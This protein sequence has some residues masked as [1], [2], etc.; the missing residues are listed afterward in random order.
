MLLNQEKSVLAFLMPRYTEKGEMKN[1]GNG[2]LIFGREIP[3]YGVFFFLGILLAAGAAL[4]LAHKKRA[5]P[6]YEVV[7]S[8]V[9]TMIGAILGAKLLFLAVSLPELIRESIPI[10]AAIKG[11]FVF[12]GGF[13]GGFLGLWIYT[14]QFKM[15]LLPFVCLYATVVPLGHAFG[16]VGCYFAGCCYGIPYDGW[17]AVVYHETLGRT[18][19][20][21][22][23]FPV[24]LLESLLLLCLFAVLLVLYL[25]DRG[26]LCPW[27]YLASYGVIRFLLEFLRYD[28]ERGRL[29]WLST[30]QW[31]SVGLLLWTWAWQGGLLARLR[32]KSKKKEGSS[33][34]E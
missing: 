21:V 28:A 14:K 33:H 13:L 26:A 29:L 12:Y 24:Q 19:L 6:L 10:I 17:G 9:Y 22:P 8:A 30:S 2:F 4:L 20:E 31:V 5:M 23:L 15:K 3:L 27:V 11:G 7:Y 34:E 25:R 32:K 16:R 1:M 18:P